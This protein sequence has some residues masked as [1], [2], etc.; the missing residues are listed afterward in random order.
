MRLLLVLFSCIWIVYTMNGADRSILYGWKYEWLK[1]YLPW[2][3]R[4]KKSAENDLS[5]S[6]S[7]ENTFQS[8]QIN[9]LQ[10]R[11]ISIRMLFLFFIS[12][13]F[14]TTFHSSI[15]HLNTCPRRY[16]INDFST[17]IISS[18]LMGSEYQYESCWH[19]SVAIFRSVFMIYIC[20]WV[21][22]TMQ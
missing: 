6:N 2:M 22:K 17:F 16:E 20:H 13:R 3:V 4:V 12:R 18:L 1:S 10:V 5:N 19:S 9:T 21:H 11:S 14:D 8:V 15:T 7:V